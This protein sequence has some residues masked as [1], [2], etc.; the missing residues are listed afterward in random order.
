MQYTVETLISGNSDIIGWYKSACDRWKEILGE[1]EAIE[2]IQKLADTLSSQQFWFEQNCG[3][4]WRGQEIMVVVGIGQFYTTD[5]GFDGHEKE[6]LA[7]YKAFQLSRCS[8]EVQG[9]A[10]DVAD[11]YSIKGLL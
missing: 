7:V 2:N 10:D 4:R 8:L 3:G 11:F 6:V 5:T 1:P 9:I